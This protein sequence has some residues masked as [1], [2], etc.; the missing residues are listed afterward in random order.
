MTAQHAAAPR[1]RLRNLWAVDDR[2]HWNTVSYNVHEY[3]GNSE[4]VETTDEA[5]N[6]TASSLETNR[7]SVTGG[8]IYRVRRR[9][10]T[11]R[12]SGLSADYG[13]GQTT[14]LWTPVLTFTDTANTAPGIGITSVSA[15]TPPDTVTTISTYASPYTLAHAPTYSSFQSPLAQLLRKV[16]VAYPLSSEA[17]AKLANFIQRLSANESDLAE[18]GVIPNLAAF[19]GL[20]TFLVS[21][22]WV[23]VPALTI[24]RGGAFAA[25]WDQERTARVRL[26]F[27]GS[28]RA[29]WVVVNTGP[30]PTNGSGE[31][32]Q[33]QL[34]G[35]LRA[36]NAKEW[37]AA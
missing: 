28:T 26:D 8:L 21:H 16:H 34:D 12:A 36:Y 22:P 24:T 19:D 13:H 1:P 29:R 7:A 9:R 31:V 33:K 23:R 32:D 5:L 15:V 6:S 3:A 18:E 11:R 4:A 35:I 2:E 25:I 10:G 30:A 20:I 17:S 37:M 14:A 27:V